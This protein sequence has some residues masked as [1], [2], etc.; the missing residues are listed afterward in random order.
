[1]N[2]T[3]ILNSPPIMHDSDVMI[4]GMGEYVIECMISSGVLGDV[5]TNYI[6]NLEDNGAIEW[7]LD[8]L[9]HSTIDDL[10]GDYLVDTLDLYSAISQYVVD[11][12]T[13]NVSKLGDCLPV[14]LQEGS[15][16]YINADFPLD[17]LMVLN[18]TEVT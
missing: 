3:L 10:S 17:D 2:R 13:L 12:I 16:C 14:L 1:M 6:F 5:V 7:E 11:F 8:E 9:I 18:F 15:H 4:R